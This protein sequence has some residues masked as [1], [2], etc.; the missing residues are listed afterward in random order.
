MKSE[1]SHKRPPTSRAL[2]KQIEAEREWIGRLTKEKRRLFV[3]TMEAAGHCVVPLEGV[4]AVASTTTQSAPDGDDPYARFVP[5]GDLIDV[6][7]LADAVSE[8]CGAVAAGG[9]KVIAPRIAVT[10]Y[11]DSPATFYTATATDG[12]TYHVVVAEAEGLALVQPENCSG[13]AQIFIGDLRLEDDTSDL[14]LAAAVIDAA[15]VR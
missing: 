15:F 11:A 6:D 10:S 2:R 7:E 8:E 5:V 14:Q 4:D 12:R 3:A 1:G 9:L 13:W